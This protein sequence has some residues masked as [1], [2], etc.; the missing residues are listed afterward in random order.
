LI[1]DK[2]KP[3]RLVLPSLRARMGDWVYYIS[4]MG[5][6]DIARRISPLQLMYSSIPLQELLQRQVLPQRGV[7]IAEYLST[8]RQRFFNALVVGTYGGD[9][10]WHETMIEQKPPYKVDLPES[11]EGTLGFLV[12][13]GS[14]RLFTIDGQHRVAGIRK[15]IERHPKLEDEEVCVILVRGV[16]AEYRAKDQKGF[17]RTRR[18]FTTLNRYAKPVSKKD[19]IAL[20]EDDAVAIITRRFVDEY[21]LFSG[22]KI[23]IK[24]NKSI[25]VSDK[26][27]LT[28]IVALYDG[29]DIY[30]SRGP[31]PQ[32][33]RFKRSRPK[34]EEVEELY[35]KGVRLW[36]TYCKRFPPLRELRDSSADEQVAAKYRHRGGGHILFRPIGLLMS[37]KVVRSLMD[38]AK[39]SREKAILQLAKVPMELSKDPWV[40]LLFDPANGRMIT[41]GENQNAA[42]KLLYHAVG[43]D[44]KDLK[45]SPDE[46]RKELAGILKIAEDEVRLP[47]Y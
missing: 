41:A 22:A 8:H 38:H 37:I 10:K 21:A 7:E 43:G 42:R 18:L 28:S 4:F 16:T 45:T 5:M 9:P 23:S 15:A 29:L 6:K 32:W 46:L 24:K 17:E 25:S 35:K 39:L 34:D 36:N 1:T 14:E 20:D 3:D 31:K 47:K 19:I 12:L 11:M 13:D 40:N 26:T 27:S 2:T 44:L 30:L 33:K